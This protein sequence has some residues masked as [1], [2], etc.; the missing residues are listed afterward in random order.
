MLN[1]A[2]GGGGGNSRT[3]I[4]IKKKTNPLLTG[5]NPGQGTWFW[6]HKSG[7]KRARLDKTIV[8]IALKRT[9]KPEFLCRM[10]KL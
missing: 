2:C 10:S 6:S 5:L 4:E 9:R 3:Q 7:I 1:C 8:P